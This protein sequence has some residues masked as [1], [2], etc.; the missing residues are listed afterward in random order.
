MVDELWRYLELDRI[1][2]ISIPILIVLSIIVAYGAARIIFLEQ[3]VNTGTSLLA[4]LIG[5]WALIFSVIYGQKQKRY[6][7]R[8][9]EELKQLI[10]ANR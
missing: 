4:Y 6:F 8:K 2:G 9:F 10:L 5:I 7:D 3:N 1:L